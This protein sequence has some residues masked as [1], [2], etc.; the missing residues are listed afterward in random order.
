MSV[1]EW[2]E[3]ENAGESPVEG[4]P[5]EFLDLEKLAKEAKAS[6]KWDEGSGCAV[7]RV[8]ATVKGA[9]LERLLE[10]CRLQG[11]T[12]GQWATETLRQ[13]LLSPVITSYLRN[14]RK[15]KRKNSSDLDVEE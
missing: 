14:C 9:N 12:P 6:I 7:T 3:S 15:T 10:F 8:S 5:P 1:E 13:A 4:L 11:I 2:E